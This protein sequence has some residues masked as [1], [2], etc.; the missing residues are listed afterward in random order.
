MVFVYLLLSLICSAVKELIEQGSVL[1]ASLREKLAVDPGFRPKNLPQN[2]GP[3]EA[4][5]LCRFG[6]A[7]N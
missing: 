3:D 7:V 1:H 2:P 5:N 6:A 4:K